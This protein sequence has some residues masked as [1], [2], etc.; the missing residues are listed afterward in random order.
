MG[1][2]IYDR[3]LS[4]DEILRHYQSWTSGNQ[5]DLEAGEK[6]VALYLFDEGSGNVIH[7]RADSSTDLLIPER[8]FVLNEPFLTPPWDEFHP[9]WGYW[10]DISVNV[11]GFVPVGFFFYAYFS[12]MRKAENSAAVTIGL[13]FAL[14]LTIEILQ[15]FLPTRNSGMTDIFTNTL[16]TAIG[17]IAFSHKAVQR[18]FHG[19]YSNAGLDPRT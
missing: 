16:G 2:A 10:K 18:M 15:A 17:V 13:G 19:L 3:E 14:S 12:L 7:N 4:G 1:L 11:A 9:G 5:R 8:F 6:M